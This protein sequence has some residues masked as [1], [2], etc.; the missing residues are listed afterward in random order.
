MLRIE[1]QRFGRLVV[2]N[3]HHSYGSRR[4]FSCLCDCGK[5]V[6][7]RG[8]QL[9]SGHTSSCGCFQKETMQSNLKKGRVCK[10]KPRKEKPRHIPQKSLRQKYPR[11]YRIHQSMKSR[12]YYVKNKCYKYYGGRGISICDEWLESF[13][14]FALWALS[15]GYDDSLTIDRIDVNSNY[16]PQNCRWI[17]NAEQQKNKQKNSPRIA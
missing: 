17:T 11:L 13:N 10:N 16:C 9:T 8:D 6:I 2:I 4:F 15:N 12:C 7:V 5:Q 14:S 1:G 3:Y